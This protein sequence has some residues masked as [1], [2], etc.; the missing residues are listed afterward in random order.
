MP[1]AV[2]ASLRRWARTTAGDGQIVL[3]S[4][5]PGLGE[6]RIAM[7]LEERLPAGS[8]MPFRTRP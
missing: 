6:S 4:G 3:I 1:A 2:A 8:D 7:A 5:E